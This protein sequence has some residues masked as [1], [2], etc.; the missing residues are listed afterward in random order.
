MCNIININMK[1]KVMCN[2][3]NNISNN[4]KVMK[5]MCVMNVIWP[6]MCNVCL[7]LIM[8]INDQ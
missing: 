1:W 8:T 7:I 6:I 2:N 4:V 3:N 5:I